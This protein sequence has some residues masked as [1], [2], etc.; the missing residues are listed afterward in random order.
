MCTTDRIVAEQVRPHWDKLERHHPNAT[1]PE[2]MTHINNT[3]AREAVN[4]LGTQITDLL[5]QAHPIALTTCATIN[6]Q[7]GT[8]GAHHRPRQVSKQRKKKS[9][10]QRKK[11][12]QK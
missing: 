4:D 5:A 9:L 11:H 1:H 10:P 8:V 2:P 7:P 3:P 6:I 12:Q